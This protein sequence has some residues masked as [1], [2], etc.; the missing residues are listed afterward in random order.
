MEGSTSAIF[1]VTR[2]L[3]LNSQDRHDKQLGETYLRLKPIG[4]KSPSKE[5]IYRRLKLL[6][7]GYSTDKNDSQRLIGTQTRALLSN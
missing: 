5:G 3:N 6:M 7:K 1:I 2:A 4:L